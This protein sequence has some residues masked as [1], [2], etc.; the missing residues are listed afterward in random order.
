MRRE[1]VVDVDRNS[2]LHR[3]RERIRGGENRPVR[4]FE[5]G[6]A[7]IDA[8]VVAARAIERV[9]RLPHVGAL[10][11]RKRGGGQSI[12]IKLDLKK[13]PTIEASES[14]LREVFTN[15]ILNS[16]DAMP[17]GGTITVTTDCD[18]KW[19]IV[20][21][22]DTGKG[23]S[24]EICQRCFEPFFSTK[25]RNGTGLGLSMAYGIVQKWGG[26]IAAESELGKGTIMTICL[27]AEKFPPAKK[28]EITVDSD[29]VAAMRILVADDNSP[30]REIVT[31]HLRADGHTVDT[32][33]D[34]PQILK[35]CNEKK[36][37]LILLDRVLGIVDGLK[38]AATIS[39]EHPE[40]RIILLTG[41]NDPTEDSSHQPEGIDFV[42][43][44]PVTQSDLRWA[45]GNVVRKRP[46][47]T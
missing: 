30:S 14:R 35:L 36:F 46:V 9:E 32:A 2:A 47:S 28:N 12:E 31:R 3:E 17:Q 38:V 22:I 6:E 39:K 11:C 16:V 44:K 25:G 29:V 43:E 40:I 18:D 33:A 7:D 13:V 8:G 15:L 4:A 5:D 37:D 1:T 23:M 34:G 27:P 26:T 45:I 24:D 20:K 19:V 42:L 41:Y 10:G 21:V